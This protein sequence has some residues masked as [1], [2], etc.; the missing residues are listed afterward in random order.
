MNIKK[1][2]KRGISAVVG[3]TIMVALVI[4]L[5]AIVWTVVTGVVEEELDSA[6]SCFGN[7]DKITLNDRYTC[8]NLSENRFYFSISSKINVT[9]IIV[10]ISGERSIKSFKINEVNPYDYAKNFV[11]VGYGEPLI[12]PRE[13]EG[14][15]Y[16]INTSHSEFKISEIDAIEIAPVIGGEQCDVSDSI[17]QIGDCRAFI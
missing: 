4:G 13:N 17:L 10:S 11:D 14:K 6:T 7:F 5:T 9:E 1:I 3:T 15:T 12:L 16:S 2:N 8:N